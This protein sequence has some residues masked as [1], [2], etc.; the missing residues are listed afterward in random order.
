MKASIKSDLDCI[1]EHILQRV[2]AEAIYLFGSHAYGTPTEDSDLDIYVVVPDAVKQNPLRLGA[3]ILSGLYKKT[4]TPVD[5]M[6]GQRSVFQRR[7]REPTLQRQ[8]AEKG[9]LLYG[10]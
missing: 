3:D 8:I 7:R 2:P 5:I 6:V 1:R 9:V 10:Q 4:Q